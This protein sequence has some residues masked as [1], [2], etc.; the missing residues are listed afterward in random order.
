MSASKSAPKPADNITEF[1]FLTRNNLLKK[2]LTEMN[3]WNLRGEGGGGLK[4]DT[5]VR[6]ADNLVA[7]CELIV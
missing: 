7:I 5:F 3:T 1:A 2:N 4:D 6:L